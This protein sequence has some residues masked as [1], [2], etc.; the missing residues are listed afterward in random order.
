MSK[1]P[2]LDQLRESVEK[3]AIEIESI[4]AVFLFGSRARN[5]SD[6]N[7]WDIC[8]LVDG[9]ENESWYTIWH[10]EYETWKKRFCSATG[11][12]YDDETQFCTVTSHE[13]L[14][15]LFASNFLLYQS[16]KDIACVI[17]DLSSWLLEE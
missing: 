17:H 13:I 5:E 10:H 16:N 11:L 6:P 9:N 15:G 12:P 2:T 8:V 14:S 7:D 3:W 4:S 1:E